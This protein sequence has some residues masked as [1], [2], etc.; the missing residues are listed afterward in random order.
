MPR[1]FDRLRERLLS[2]GVGG[3]QAGRYIAELKDHLEDLRTEERQAG[4]SPEEAFSRARRRLGD[5]D[6]LAE[7]MVARRE[8]QAWG[9]RA[10]ITAYVVAPSVLL[11]VT[12]VFWLAALVAACTWLRHGGP[13]PADWASWVRPRADRVAWFSNTMLPIVLGWGLAA[14]AIR[15]RAPLLWPMLGL[16]VLAAVG[17]ALQV[18]VTLPVGS[19]PGEI[20][21]RPVLAGT[22]FGPS[23]YGARVAL[24][25]AATAAPYV[26][27]H[28]WRG[29]FAFRGQS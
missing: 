5:A 3:A 2:A 16:I 13:G 11:T 17:A 19:A 24:D 4:Q 15:Q 7:A 9:A 6:A 21:L 8:F 26:L 20:N 1:E 27:F 10:P 14:N 28:L 23:G 18:D 25:F 22:P 29:R 12:I